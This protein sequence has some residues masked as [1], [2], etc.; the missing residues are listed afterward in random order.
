MEGVVSVFICD[1][2][3]EDEEFDNDEDRYNCNYS[4]AEEV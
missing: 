2:V 4:F 3:D 1:K